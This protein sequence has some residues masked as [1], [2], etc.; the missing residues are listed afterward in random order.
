MQRKWSDKVG[1]LAGSAVPAW[2]LPGETGFAPKPHVRWR[3]A[4]APHEPATRPSELPR[5]LRPSIA[6]LVPPARPPSTYYPSSPPA[7]SS[8]P[9]QRPRQGPPRRA[10]HDLVPAPITYAALGPA[11]PAA[12]DKG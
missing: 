12:R 3:E 8:P 6:A 9:G 1:V 4:A 10:P 7:L 11:R 5:R 2:P